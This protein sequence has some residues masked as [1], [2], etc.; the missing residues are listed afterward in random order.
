MQKNNDI[1]VLRA[2]GII[3][4]LFSHLGMFTP[5]NPEWV[6]YTQRFT[7][8]WSGVDLFFCVSGFVIMKSLIKTMITQIMIIIGKAQSHFG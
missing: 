4:V 6:N 8:W 7:Y 1:E 5:W 3:C 2:V